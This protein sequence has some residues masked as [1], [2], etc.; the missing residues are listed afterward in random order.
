MISHIVLLKCRADVTEQQL[1]NM[2]CA[3]HDL[4]EKIPG[5]QSCTSGSNCS[6]E[7][8]NRGYSHAFHM[9]F[10]S[11]QSR[12]AYLTHPQH[13]QVKLLIADALEKTE[14][15]LLVMDF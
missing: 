4:V 11:E 8:M 7:G 6:P 13:E 2:F 3:L 15:N 1:S 10:C 9:H 14:D 5:L 12:D